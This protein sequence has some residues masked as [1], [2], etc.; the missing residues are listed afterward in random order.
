MDKTGQNLVKTGPK[1]Q[2][3]FKDQKH[4]IYGQNEEHLKTIVFEKKGR[5]KHIWPK[6][7]KFEKI[8]LKFFWPFFKKTKNKFLWQKSEKIKVAFGRNGPKRV[9]LAKK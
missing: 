4:S 5:N 2:K 1:S 6:I 8:C 3:K 7:V 9:F